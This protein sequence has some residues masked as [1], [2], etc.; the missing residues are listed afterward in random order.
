M[1]MAMANGFTAT[2]Q[3]EGRSWMT[4]TVMFRGSA[5]F[6]RRLARPSRRAQVRVARREF[7]EP[8]VR[9]LRFLTILIEDQGAVVAAEALRPGDQR[10]VARDLVMLER[11]RGGDD[12]GVDRLLV[13]FPGHVLGLGDDAVDR[14]AMQVPRGGPQQAEA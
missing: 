7:R 8:L 5:I 14:R 1:S 11:L 13:R 3:A 10:A 9:R 6:F 12:R 4:A 2:R